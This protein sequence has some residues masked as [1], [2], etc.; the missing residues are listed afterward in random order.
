MLRY[1]TE[2][3]Y[4]NKIARLEKQIELLQEKLEKLSTEKKEKN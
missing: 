4:K 3:Y 2:D 1:A